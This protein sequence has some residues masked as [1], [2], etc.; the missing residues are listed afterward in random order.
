MRVVCLDGLKPSKCAEFLTIPDQLAAKFQVVKQQF[1]SLETMSVC[2]DDSMMKRVEFKLEGIQGNRQLAYLGDAYISLYLAQ[3]AFDSDFDPSQF[4]SWRTSHTS[5]T[6]LAAVYDRTF[7][8]DVI[9]YFGKDPTPSMKQ[10]ATFMEALVGALPKAER[11]ELIK[12][13]LLYMHQSYKHTQSNNENHNAIKVLGGHI[14]KGIP[15]FLQ[16]TSENPV[17]NGQ[18][19]KRNKQNPQHE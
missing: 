9:L 5:D 11:R 2:L 16:A 15:C 8:E 3:L 19:D 4:Q 17:E 12:H 7:Q 13:I 14:E 10:K 6:H 1:S 18:M